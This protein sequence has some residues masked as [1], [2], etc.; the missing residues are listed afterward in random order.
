MKRRLE[1]IVARLEEPPEPGFFP[2]LR[3][4]VDEI[5]RLDLAE[6][7][8]FPHA[9]FEF[10]S[11]RGPMGGPEYFY[12]WTD[13]TGAESGDAIAKSFRKEDGGL[14]DLLSAET[15]NAS[16]QSL[17]R[18]AKRWIRSV[19][20]ITEIETYPALQAYVGRSPAEV[21][22]GDPFTRRLAEAVQLLREAKRLEAN[23]NDDEPANSWTRIVPITT[24]SYR[25]ESWP[26]WLW[27]IQA[28]SVYD[29]LC[30]NGIFS[31]RRNEAN[32]EV[33]LV[34]EQP[35]QGAARSFPLRWEGR[36]AGSDFEG[37]ADQ[38]QEWLST[39]ERERR[40]G[41]ESAAAS[42]QTDWPKRAAILKRGRAGRSRVG[43]AKRDKMMFD[44]KKTRA[45][46][47]YE[48]AGKEFGVEGAEMKKAYDR[49]RSAERRKPSP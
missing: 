27:R 24:A 6:R 23:S 36:L 42:D 26:S 33:A 48:E 5:W 10:E 17:L 41:S 16:R 40:T 35:G 20:S 30:P 2:A 15:H 45:H 46:L 28:Q 32:E 43:N 9:P 25:E 37:I 14:V 21:A 44:F 18:I 13:P 39:R 34:V 49:H 22:E 1:E 11:Y 7:L 3:P 19:K 47:T 29:R 38:L 12:K 8:G 31:T 4:L